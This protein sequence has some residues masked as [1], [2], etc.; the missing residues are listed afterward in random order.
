MNKL[1]LILLLLLPYA[2]IQSQNPGDL[3]SDFGNN[4]TIISDFGSASFEAMTGVLLQSDGKIIAIGG[5]G[6]GTTADLVI[7]RYNVQRY[8]CLMNLECSMMQ[9]VA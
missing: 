9:L 1:R 8:A 6:L 7:A 4:G 3:D 5:T 2:L